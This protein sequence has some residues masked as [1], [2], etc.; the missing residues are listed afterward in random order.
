MT[1]YYQTNLDEQGQNVSLAQLLVEW[2]FFALTATDR[3]QY[4]AP[5][6]IDKNTNGYSVAQAEGLLWR[7]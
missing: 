2:G 1:A 6:I 4:Q 5:L 3:L 7:I